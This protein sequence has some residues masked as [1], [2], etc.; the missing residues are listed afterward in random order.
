MAEWS[1]HW[2]RNAAVLG[3]SPTQAT[4]WIFSSHPEFK[5]SATLVKDL[6][7]TRVKLSPNFTRH[8]LITHTNNKIKNTCTPNFLQFGFKCRKDN[9]FFF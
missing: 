8:H 4:Y 7:K 6:D 5:F 9:F 3:S 2:T 1:V